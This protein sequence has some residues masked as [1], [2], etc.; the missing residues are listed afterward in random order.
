MTDL[1]GMSQIVSKALQSKELNV[2]S[3]LVLIKALNK[4]T[5]AK[6]TENDFEKYWNVAQ[7]TAERIGVQYIEPRRRK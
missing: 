3:A 1:L 6:R 7:E 4:E 2:T 5:A